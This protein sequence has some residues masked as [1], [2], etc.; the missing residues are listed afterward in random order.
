[1]PAARLLGLQ[2]TMPRKSV[3][4]APTP[5]GEQTAPPADNVSERDLVAMLLKPAADAEPAASPS[6]TNTSA[7]PSPE[8]AAE[9]E[10]TH[11]PPTTDQPDSQPPPSEPPATEGAAEGEQTESEPDASEP[12]AEPD[13]EQPATRDFEY[14]KCHVPSDC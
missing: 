8:P 2:N 9:P 14:P 5:A 12:T 7:Q 1:M 11:E 4:T 13:G 10:A 6:A 3:K